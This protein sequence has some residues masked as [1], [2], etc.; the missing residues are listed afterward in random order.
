MTILL[1][2]CLPRRLG[3]LL[4]GHEVK[5]TR[6]MNWHGLSNGELLAAADSRFEVFITVDKNLDIRSR[7]PR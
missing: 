2:E 1:G 6:Q 4:A 3:P 5:T 7:W